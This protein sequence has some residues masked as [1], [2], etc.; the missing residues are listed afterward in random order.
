M[1]GQQR[2]QIIMLQKKLQ[3]MA[4]FLCSKIYEA[5]CKKLGHA[6]WIFALPT[7][8]HKEAQ[9]KLDSSVVSSTDDR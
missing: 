4:S 7:A 8:A 1:L 9:S 6:F 2:K 3:A 5:E